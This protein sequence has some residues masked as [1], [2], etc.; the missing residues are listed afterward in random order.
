[1]V[2]SSITNDA[3]DFVQVESE[4][5]RELTI[6]LPWE[7]TLI[8]VGE[9]APYEVSVSRLTVPTK[10]GEIIQFHRK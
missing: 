6:D 2:S 4:K 8:Q 9:G 10:A 7:K 1:M 3:V 5:G